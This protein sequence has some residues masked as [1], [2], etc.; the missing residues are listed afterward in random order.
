MGCLSSGNP[1]YFS[2][3]FS[4]ACVFRANFILESASPLSAMKKRHFGPLA[5]IGRRRKTC[6]FSKEANHLRP[7]DARDA[8]FYIQRGMVRLTVVS[9]PGK[10]ATIATSTRAIFPEKADLQ[11]ASPLRALRRDS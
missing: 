4:E 2:D 6:A 1:P 9:K 7:G 10:E 5:T 8:V 3:S 11:S